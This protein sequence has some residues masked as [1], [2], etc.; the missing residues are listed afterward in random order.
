MAKVHWADKQDRSHLYGFAACRSLH[1]PLPWV[2]VRTG[3]EGAVTLYKARVTCKRC[4]A[5]LRKEK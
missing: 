2:G 4:L 1:T 3:D 5:A